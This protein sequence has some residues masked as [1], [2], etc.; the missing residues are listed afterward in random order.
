[1]AKSGSAPGSG[2]ADVD[3]DVMN[4]PSKN[5]TGPEK[6][7]SVH[8]KESELGVRLL[9]LVVGKSGVS[10]VNPVNTSPPEKLKFDRVIVLVPLAA[11]MPANEPEET[12][13]TK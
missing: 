10:I 3:D 6:D 13:M 9:T 5:T 4:S 1:M 12:L 2:T 11:Y 7:C 8:D